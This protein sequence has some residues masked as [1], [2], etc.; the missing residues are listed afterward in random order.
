MRASAFNANLLPAIAI[1]YFK[2]CLLAAL[3][4]FVSTFASSNIFT[5]VVM[6]FV[7][8]IGHLQATAR[9][10][11]LQTTQRRLATNTFLAFVALVFPR[12]AGS[13]TW[14]MIVVGTSPFR[15]LFLNTTLLGV[16]YTD[17]LPAARRVVFYGKEL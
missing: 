11:W 4:L 15:P 9:E 5:I 14:S 8:F 17:N 7:Y 3:T 16:F 1:I 2:G 6:A 10:Y 13:L 12:S